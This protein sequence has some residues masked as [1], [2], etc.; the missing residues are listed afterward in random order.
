MFRSVQRAALLS[1][2]LK[3][4]TPIDKVRN[5]NILPKPPKM[6]HLFEADTPDEVKNA[7]VSDSRKSVGR[8]SQL[9]GRVVL[10][11][12]WADDEWMDRVFILSL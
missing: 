12:V 2:H 6:S 11:L 4:R 8:S 7:K 10:R 9:G 5:I 1:S 3:A